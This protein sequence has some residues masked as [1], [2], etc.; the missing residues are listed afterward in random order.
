MIIDSHSHLFSE[1]FCDDLPLVIDRAKAE[2]ISQILMP[3]IDSTSINSMLE[4]ASKYPDYCLPMMGLHP[5]SVKEDYKKELALV[6]EYLDGQNKFVAVGEIGLDLYWDKTFIKEQ[7]IVFDQQIQWALD[8]K[9]PIVIHSRESTDEMVEVLSN[10]KDT[11]LKGVFHS[12][13]G[14]VEDVQKLLPF[15]N[16]VFGINGVV[17]FKN[18]LLPQS[19]PMIPLNR[20]ILETDS[21]YL[22]PVPKRGK[23]NE[24]AYLSN[25]LLRLADIYEIDKFE[26]AKATLNNTKRVFD[27]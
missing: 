24:S 22:A 15:E 20:I 17:T 25:I 8:Y 4:V 1:E 12:F 19:L 18:S 27:L 6:K 3:N 16:F 13:T 9:L 21:P 23:R 26:L 14:G 11:S 7:Q 10:Y 2:G 5:T